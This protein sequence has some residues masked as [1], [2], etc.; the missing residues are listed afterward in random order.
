MAAH[1]LNDQYKILIA[2][3]DPFF[4]KTVQ[5]TLKKHFRYVSV[6]ESGPQV[7]S[8]CERFRIDLVIVGNKLPG[9]LG[10]EVVRRLE[11]TLPKLKRILTS[12]LDTDPVIE[13]ALEYGIIDRFIQKPLDVNDLVWEAEYLLGLK[14]EPPSQDS[15]L[16]PHGLEEDED[17]DTWIPSSHEPRRKA[18]ERQLLLRSLKSKE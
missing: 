15:A 13:S 14:L 5:H 12:D 10:I 1:S 11:R 8:H 7:L 2:D 3:K 4:R 16:D 6:A 17:E 18:H 9:M